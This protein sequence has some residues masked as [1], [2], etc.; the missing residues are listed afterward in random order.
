MILFLLFICYVRGAQQS[1]QSSF[2]SNAE[3]MSKLDDIK[4]K[5]SQVRIPYN[6]YTIKL[7][8]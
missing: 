8:Q 5:L 4:S 2:I 6:I 3:H 7:P 1:F